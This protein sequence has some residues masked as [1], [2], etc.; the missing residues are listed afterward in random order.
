MT[1][2]IEAITTAALGLALD[3]ATLRQTAH[4][5][6]VANAGTEGYVPVQ[7]SFEAQLE[8]ARA[9]LQT[10]GR[11]DGSALAGV[12]PAL[13]SVPRSGLEPPAVALDVELAAMARNTT[14]AQALLTGLSRHFSILSVAVSDGRK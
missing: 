12:R 7:V 13:Q 9:Q 8:E 4:A 3:A 1:E 11:L 2:G 5:A 10:A 14:H 6:N